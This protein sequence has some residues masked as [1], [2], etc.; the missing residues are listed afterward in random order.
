MHTEKHKM[1]IH[2]ILHLTPQDWVN[3]LTTVT[4][5][6]NEWYQNGIKMKARYQDISMF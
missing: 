4:M 5:H 1:L 2:V 6:V 3:P